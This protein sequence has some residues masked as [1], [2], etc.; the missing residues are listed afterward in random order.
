ML[1][2]LRWLRDDPESDFRFLIDETAVDYPGKVSRFELVCHL[3]S[4]SK[5]H[6]LRVKIPIDE[7]DAWAHSLDPLW[8]NANWLEREVYDMFGIRFEGHPDLRRILMYP[9]FEGY[10]LR[11]DYPVARRQ[12]IVPERDPIETPWPSR[13]QGIRR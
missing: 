1:E 7:G 9:S 11:K 6:R 4:L 10:P 3:F 13:T 12:P 5:G 8:K 2:I